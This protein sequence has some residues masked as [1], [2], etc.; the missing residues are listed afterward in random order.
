MTQ[1]DPLTMVAYGILLIPFIKYLDD[2]FQSMHQSWYAVDDRVHDSFPMIYDY[3]VKHAEQ[4]TNRPESDNL[5]KF[6]DIH[7][8]KSP[9]TL[10]KHND[11]CLRYTMI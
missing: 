1:G 11:L 9:N 2:L 7:D 4:N 6:A 8:L 10:A 3:F 5:L